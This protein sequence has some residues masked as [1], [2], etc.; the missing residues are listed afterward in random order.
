[1]TPFPK[2]KKILII[3]DER[4]SITYLM[5]LLKHDY[6]VIAATE[7]LKGLEMAA[8]VAGGSPPDL[9]LL[10]ILMQGMNG[11]QVCER[12]KSDDRTR[13]IPVIFVTAASDVNDETR[14]FELGAVD[15][16]VKPFHPAVVKARVRTQLELKLKSDMLEQFASID[17]LL[18]I[19]NRRRFD[20]MLK[21]EWARAQRTGSPLSLIM[22]DI[23]HFK[24]YNDHFGHAGGDECLKQVATIL[25]NCLKRPTDFIARYGGEEIVVI[26]PETSSDG[27]VMIAELM[28]REIS[29]ERIAHPASPTAAHVTISVGTATALSGG[30]IESAQSLLEAADAQ[31]Y[32]SKNTGRNRVTVFRG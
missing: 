4:S 27:A 19:Y 32:T 15:Y 1:M 24:L 17:A 14:G 3:D 16:I 6:K 23:D 8:G 31:L 26:L 20:E 13:D 2:E 10:D 18:N 7:G 5:S 29:G 22:I 28:C 21:I 30:P 12:L 9:I 25:K 11:Y